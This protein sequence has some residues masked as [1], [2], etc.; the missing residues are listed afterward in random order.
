VFHVRPFSPNWHLLWPVLTSGNSS[1]NLSIIVAPCKSPDLP[2]YDAQTF[3]LIP[4]RSKEQRSEQ[5][6]GFDDNRRLTP[7]QRLL[8]ASCSSGQRFAFGF[9]PRFADTPRHP[10]R[11]AKFSSCRAHN[12]KGRV[13]QRTLPFLLSF[14]RLFLSSQTSQSDK[15]KT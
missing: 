9:T 2:G 8:S 4:V 7:L 15:T 11:S 12:R 10:C 3:A 13:L 5:V 6:P 1:C 14:S